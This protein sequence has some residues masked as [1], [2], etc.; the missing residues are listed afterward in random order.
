[1]PDPPAEFPVSPGDPA[2]G[3]VK[4]QVKMLLAA[5]LAAVADL[6]HPAVAQVGASDKP[7]DPSVVAG[8]QPSAR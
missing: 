1:V 4:D 7:D 6:E 3:T 8:R 2:D 5:V